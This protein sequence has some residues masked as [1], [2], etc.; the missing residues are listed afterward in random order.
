MGVIIGLGYYVNFKS[1]GYRICIYVGIK[2]EK[3]FMYKNVVVEL[4]KIFEI[5]EC[6]FIIGFYIMLIKFYLCDNE[7]LMDLLNLKI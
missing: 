5:V 6:Y 3:G 1:L 4:K 2:L 7:Y